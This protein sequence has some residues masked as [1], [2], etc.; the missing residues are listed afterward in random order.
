[1]KLEKY[2]KKQIRDFKKWGWS[3]VKTK[4]KN[5][6]NSPTITYK[7]I[8]ILNSKNTKKTILI[9]NGAEKTVSEVHRV[10]HLGDKLSIIKIPYLTI[11]VNLF[12]HLITKKIYDFDLLYIHRSYYQDNIAQLI[13]KFQSKGKKVIYDVD[14]LIF[15]KDQIKKISFLKNADHNIRQHFTENTNNYLKIMKMADLVITPTDFLSKYIKDKYKIKTEVLRNHLDQKSLDAGKKIFIKNRN[16]N[17]KNIVIGYFPGTKTHQSDFEIIETSLFNLLGKYPNLK[18]KVVGELSLNKIFKKYKNQVIKQGKVPYSKM[19]SIYKDV[20][21]NLAPLEMN[22]DF[23]EGKSEIKYL[24]AGACGIP[25]VASAT[26]AFKYAI[27]NDVNGYL[28]YQDKDWYKYLEELIS[29]QEKRLSMGKK[30]FNHVQEKYSPTYQ[31]RELKKILR[32]I[33]FLK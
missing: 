23:C 10:F 29:N 5:R 1:V 31:S 24:F 8:K 14:D 4:I 30:A 16:K 28:C 3:G 13:N 22:N 27:K 17:K 9:L 20:D 19:M 7:I 26:D 21:I 12:N 2:L 32:K 11:T 18:L 15:D 33:N 6:L 25:T